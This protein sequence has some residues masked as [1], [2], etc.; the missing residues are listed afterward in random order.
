MSGGNGTMDT[1]G[2]LHRVCA[3]QGI[4]VGGVPTTVDNDISVTDYSPGLG[5]AARYIAGACEQS[6]RM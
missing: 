3:P 2:R 6:E 5:S 4:L 1:C